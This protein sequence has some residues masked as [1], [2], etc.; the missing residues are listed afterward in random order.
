[1]GEWLLKQVR[2][3]DC[4]MLLFGE[5]D[6]V[7]HHFWMFHDPDS[8]RYIQQ[9]GSFESNPN[10]VYQQLDHAVGRLIETANP[11]WV[12][13]CSDHGFGGA[14]DTYCTSIVLE[15][16]RLA[17]IWSWRVRWLLCVDKPHS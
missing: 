10:G 9:P 6:T 4:F 7:S 11:D 14:G 17:S 3:G 16:A 2:D 13:I 8:P 1:M 15:N 12:C 5:F